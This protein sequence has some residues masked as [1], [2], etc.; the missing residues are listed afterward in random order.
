MRELARIHGGLTRSAPWLALAVFAVAM[1][2][3][4]GLGWMDIS[5]LNTW[6]KF[7]AIAIMAI[8]MDL[9]WGYTGMLSLCQ[10]L[11]FAIG[12][13]AIGMHLAMHGPLDGEG[14]P[15]CLFV[16]SSAVSGF[17]LPWFWKPFGSF[18]AAL[19]LLAVVPGA[20]AFLFGWFAFRSRVKGVYFS[21]I[22]Q[23]LTIAFGLIFIQ[24]QLNLCGT[25]GLTNFESLLGFD[26]RLPRTKLML[27]LITVA[28]VVA[29]V[30][31]T[32]WLVRTR[33]GRV[34]IAVRDNESRLRFAGYQPVAY[35]VWI[36][37]FSAILAAVGGALYVPQN[38]IINP[39]F[40]SAKESIFV[41]VMVALGGRGTIYG[42]IVGA[43]LC[44]FLENWLSSLLA[45]NWN[46]VLGGLY[47][48]VVLFLPDGIVG[49]WRKLG[50]WLA[51]R[52]SVPAPA[53]AAPVQTGTAA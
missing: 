39:E 26:L 24:N 17:H 2:A 47:I 16:V 18:A 33:T 5:T 53:V 9:V 43:L 13:Y 21:I 23:A 11:F 4:Y 37:T 35:K 3:G 34:L 46:F 12:G 49:A 1:P 7:L 29:A 30:A 32:Q 45:N 31:F 19:A 36:F 22:T 10:S 48:A 40:M 25:N 42:A 41:V 44:K 8:G 52:S 51:R 20:V 27:Y 38:G 14:I 50:A 6:G 15:R 28:A